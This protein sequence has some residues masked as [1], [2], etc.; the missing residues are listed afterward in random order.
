MHVFCLFVIHYNSNLFV[1][2]CLL[3]V[4]CVQEFPTAQQAQE[5]AKRWVHAKL[6]P[7]SRKAVPSKGRAHGN[8]RLGL[9]LGSGLGLGLR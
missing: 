6:F 8:N 1:V 7:K 3:F 9:G 5:F 4:M 2:C